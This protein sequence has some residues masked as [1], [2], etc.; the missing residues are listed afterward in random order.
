MTPCNTDSKSSG[1][2]DE[3]ISGPKRCSVCHTPTNDKANNQN[4]VAPTKD[5]GCLQ[6]EIFFW[7]L[8]SIFSLWLLIGWAFNG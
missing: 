7:G 1:T 2:E 5:Q 8:S 6:W 3:G 4:A